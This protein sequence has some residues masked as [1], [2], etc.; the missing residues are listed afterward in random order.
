MK[1]LKDDV[2]NL[3]DA[4]YCRQ[5]LDWMMG[6]NFSVVYTLLTGGD[7]TL[8][9]GRVVLPTLN[10]IFEKESEIL[11]FKSSKFFSLKTIFSKMEDSYTGTYI[12]EEKMNFPEKERLL[13]VQSAINGKSGSI[14][15][16]TESTS[17]VSPQKLFNL[18]DL[19]GYIT[20]KYDGFSADGVLQIMQ[21][22]Y[23]IKVLTYPR[24]A[25]RYLDDSQVYGAQ[26]SLNAVKSLFK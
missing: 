8:K 11:S 22:L 24:T 13:E 9:V 20:S 25:S 3:E 17:N 2:K 7:V 15:K 12:F 18:T 26:E 4:G 6:I 5:Q 16:K 14:I 21:G 19:Q 23:E 1:N 10:L